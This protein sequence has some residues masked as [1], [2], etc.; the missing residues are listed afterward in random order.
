[1][2]QGKPERVTSLTFTQYDPANYALDH[3]EGI[4]L[5]TINKIL[6]GLFNNDLYVY[7]LLVGKM[8]GL[9]WKYWFADSAVKGYAAGDMICSNGIQEMGF[10]KKYWSSIKEIADY[11]SVANKL[12]RFDPNDEEVVA[13]YIAALGDYF[14]LGNRGL[15]RQI[16]ISLKDDNKDVVSI[17]SSWQPYIVTAEELQRRE[18]QLSDILE[19]GIRRHNTIYHDALDILDAADSQYEI[20]N[21]GKSIYDSEIAKY[22]PRVRLEDEEH[23][24]WVNFALAPAS[25]KILGLGT[26]AYDFIH[27]VKPLGTAVHFLE[28][29]VRTDGHVVVKGYVPIAMLTEIVPEEGTLEYN[30]WKMGGMRRY[31]MRLDYSINDTISKMYFKEEETVTE[32]ISET[33]TNLI[34]GQA[35]MRAA[36]RMIEEQD[37]A[38][39]SLYSILSYNPPYSGVVGFYPDSC[40]FPFEDLPNHPDLLKEGDDEIL[41]DLLDGDKYTHTFEPIERDGQEGDDAEH[42]SPVDLDTLEC[43]LFR[44]KNTMVEVPVVPVPPPV[45][46][47]D[48]T[49]TVASDLR[50]IRNFG[51]TRSPALKEILGASIIPDAGELVLPSFDTPTIA[52]TKWTWI[53]GQSILFEVPTNTQNI[54]FEVEGMMK[55]G[56]IDFSPYDICKDGDNIAWVHDLVMNHDFPKAVLKSALAE[57]FE[58]ENGHAQLIDNMDGMMSRIENC[59]LDHPTFIPF[60]Q[61]RSMDMGPLNILLTQLRAAADEYVKDEDPKG[62]ADF[63]KVARTMLKLYGYLYEYIAEDLRYAALHDCFKEL[64]SDA[65][66]LNA[67]RMVLLHKLKEFLI[68]KQIARPIDFYGQEYDPGATYEVDEYCLHSGKLHRC[69]VRITSPEEFNSSHWH[70]VTL[71]ERADLWIS[72]IREVI[73]STENDISNLVKAGHDEL[74]LQVSSL[75]DRVKDAQ[76]KY[77][78][79]RTLEFTDLSTLPNNPTDIEYEF[80]LTKY[81]EEYMANFRDIYSYLK[82]VDD[83]LGTAQELKAKIQSYLAVDWLD[84]STRAY[85][86]Y[87]LAKLTDFVKR[88]KKQSLNICLGYDKYVVKWMDIFDID[89]G[90]ELNKNEVGYTLNDLLHGTGGMRSLTTIKAKLEEDA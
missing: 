13:K 52:T 23:E 65:V 84:E 9:W 64:L 78:A 22:L 10:M 83:N 27:I 59:L 45:A 36:K 19:D 8:K 70:E 7:T 57:G 5:S 68:R 40:D 6:L 32:D 15:E 71:D 16:Y 34:S 62:T 14:H 12:P 47:A 25:N 85:L 60:M 88:Y 17:T 66:S 21:E 20:E 26:V 74:A 76:A 55:D 86:V 53:A 54:Q 28:T 24:S 73:E 29:W 77:I 75:N 51:T 63:Q 33:V 49:D 31:G 80:E 72:E 35:L 43:H 90:T 58:S 37:D 46:R 50:L 81:R 18:Y 89:G 11:G 79:E 1:M 2:K 82:E 69:I 3:A 42:P 67:S 48:D 38:T 87:Q 4:K 44:K 39:D 30:K 56:I 61:F 41:R